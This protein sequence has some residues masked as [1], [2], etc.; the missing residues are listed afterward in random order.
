MPVLTNKRTKYS[1]CQN[2]GSPQSKAK[3]MTKA[4]AKAIVK[5]LQTIYMKN[6][7][8][9]DLVSKLVLKFIRNV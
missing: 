2:V 1:M 3:A 8:F 4:K 5:Y 9:I 6:N 7:E